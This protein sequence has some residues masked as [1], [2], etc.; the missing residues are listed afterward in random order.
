MVPNHCVKFLANL[1][2]A[3]STL[4]NVT[5]AQILSLHQKLLHNDGV[6]TPG[7]LYLLLGTRVNFSRRLSN[8]AGGASQGKGLSE[9]VMRDE[10][11]ESLDDADEEE[12]VTNGVDS[13]LRIHKTEDVEDEPTCDIENLQT[14][15]GPTT[16]HQVETAEGFEE[17][18]QH[19]DGDEEFEEHP[20]GQDAEN[21]ADYQEDHEE[22]RIAQ[23]EGE[24]R[25]VHGVEIEI[26]SHGQIS[27]LTDHT[28]RSEFTDDDFKSH[29]GSQQSME[30]TE[31][32]KPLLNPETVSGEDNEEEDLID[33]SDEE[34]QFPDEPVRHRTAAVV[35]AS[36]TDN[37]TDPTFIP[38]CY[39]PETCFCSSAPFSYSQNT[40]Q[41]TRSSVAVPSHAKLKKSS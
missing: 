39:R 19:A 3:S 27:A 38:P 36:R 2:Q 4:Q 10:N 7:P 13:S 22:Q 23:G 9:L 41:K 15:K 1:S 25:E 40:K 29:N 26:Q 34:I 32:A 31:T 12:I 5:L 33:Y 8:L 14:S 11:S 24:Y 35:D 30:H 16:S 37:G 18:C 17:K 28:H 6:D 21:E 20:Q